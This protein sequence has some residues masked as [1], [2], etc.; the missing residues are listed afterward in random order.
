LLVLLLLLPELQTSPA[1]SIGGL[2]SSLFLL[3][4]PWHSMCW[5][6]CSWSISAEWHAYLVFPSLARLVLSKS[7]RWMA[8]VLLACAAVVGLNDAAHHSGDI[9]NTPVVFLRCIPEFLAGMILY[10]LRETGRLPA[11][12]Q[13][14]A[15]FAA[16]LAGLAALEV[17]H[18]PDGLTVCLLAVLLLAAARDGSAFAR[19]LSWPPFPWLGDI[20]YSLYM[21]QMVALV[22]LAK[23]APHL[24]TWPH[25]LLFVAGTLALAAPISR[26][27]EY[28][29]RSFVRTLRF[30]R[31]LQA[32]GAA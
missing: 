22:A 24:S 11:L 32:Q 31:P 21:V 26:F 25:S 15:A 20:S 7:V 10:R 8:G 14:D 17:L 27:V 12:V 1:F 2:A 13:S 28:P 3:Q 6:F 16:T 18:A 9:T 23:F 30:G 5:N 19:F 29:A 4:S